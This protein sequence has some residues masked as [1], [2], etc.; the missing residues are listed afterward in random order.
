MNK[1]FNYSLCCLFFVVTS[2]VASWAQSP[3]FANSVV[4]NDI[5]FIRE[6]DPDSF[7]KVDFVGL[8]DKE[9]P[10]DPNGGSLFDKGTFVFEATFTDGNTL[11]IWCH[12]SFVGPILALEYVE[13]LCPRLGKLPAFQR[14]MLNH[15][16]IHKG[17]RTA[18]A[19]IEGQF[20]ILYSDNMDAR[21]STN[22]LE[23]T[24]F[25][26]S[27]HASYQFMYEKHP[28]WT[29]AQA[30]DPAF[31]T[32]YGQ[33]N[34]QL[35]DMAE[36]ALFAYTFL[37]YPGRLSSDIEDWLMANNS[38][39][40]DFFRMFYGVASGVSNEISEDNLTIYPNPADDIIT[41]RLPSSE[42]LETLNVFDVNGNKV[43]VSS[44]QGLEINT[45][46][47]S[48][49]MYYLQLSTDKRNYLRQIK[50]SH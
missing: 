3:L 4:S 27:V 29:S 6:A 49:G 25:H 35:E 45:R 9:M 18:F 16:V 26:E 11:E 47:L 34:P 1:I 50:V 32:Q 22:D 19:E 2:N 23:E 48:N 15:V 5:D 44:P 10:G 12:S 38:N 20:F 36:S 24:V 31:V 42:Q 28:D 30:A 41:I 33:D 21:I 14:N 37:T 46:S 39:R 17:N 8:A 7:V 43:L 40:I 13:K